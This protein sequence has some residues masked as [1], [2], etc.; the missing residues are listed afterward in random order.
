MT[1]F[2]R[3]KSSKRRKIVLYTRQ[4]PKPTDPTFAIFTGHLAREWSNISDLVV[5][6]PLPWCPKWKCLK[7]WPEWYSNASVPTKYNYFGLTVY[8]PKFFVVPVLAR[9]F[10]VPMQLLR[11]LFLAK[12]IKANFDFEA[13]NAH[14]LYPDGISA[15]VIG[16]R[17]GVPVMVTSLGTDINES[18]VKTLRGIQV[19]WCL[20]NADKISAK[21][22]DLVTKV[23][24]RL[25]GNVSV[26]LIPN[27]VD[28]LQFYPPSTQEKNLVK[29]A[30][31][32][33]VK[34]QVIVFVGRLESVKGVK[35]LIS[36]ISNLIQVKRINVRLFIIGDGAEN[37]AL[38]KLALDLGVAEYIK[39]VGN[40]DQ[41]EV[42]KYMHAA[43]VF[44][45]PSLNEGRPNVV[46]EALACGVPV[47]ASKVGGIPELV[48]TQNG[49]LVES[50][51]VEALS[52]GLYEIL[53]NLPDPILVAETVSWASWE[54]SAQSYL[55]EIEAILIN[56]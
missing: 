34:E 51:D 22:I 41:A 11:T 17:L 49:C 13:I 3:N 4:F 43:D 19:D 37:E 39:F 26:S 35:F 15:V 23:K 8:Y 21:S 27:G 31:D 24:K 53:S 55:D 25:T 9:Y 38:R 30:L 12:K 20:S 2:K 29:K 45:L 33:L 14:D 52:A 36:A 10:Q 54:S 7:R 46:I 18:P 47:V 48:N 6:C 32:L 44:C 42:V 28:K 50:G 40:I 1:K 56:E 5:I 16:K